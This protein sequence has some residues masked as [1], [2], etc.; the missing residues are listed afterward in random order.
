[1]PAYA[2]AQ[3]MCMRT[4]Q[5]LREGAH[6]RASWGPAT[7]PPQPAAAAGGHHPAAGPVPIVS[8]H[9]WALLPR[10]GAL[11]PLLCPPFGEDG[12][13]RRRWS[14]GEV[15]SQGRRRCGTCI[16]GVW[17]RLRAGFGERARLL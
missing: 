13:V 16:T 10:L 11:L 12:A 14:R 15:L 1:M 2:T 7:H 3:A 4:W 6:A 8:L 5:H 17:R 9:V